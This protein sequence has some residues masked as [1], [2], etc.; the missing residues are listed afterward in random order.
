MKWQTDP[1]N[2]N[3]KKH[4]KGEKKHIRMLAVNFK[5]N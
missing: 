5:L 2:A 1:K 4:S 3:A